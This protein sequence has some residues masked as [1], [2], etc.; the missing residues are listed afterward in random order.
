[1]EPAEGIDDGMLWEPCLIDGHKAVRINRGHPYYHK[2]Y[3]PNLSSGV[4][5]QGMDSLLWA[6]CAAELGTVNEATKRHFT[7]LRYEV[8]RLLRRL[9]DHL[10]EPDLES[11]DND[12]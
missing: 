10:P 1:M 4:T 12:T 7:E 11:N 3:V 2:V 5:V 8:S 6:L 9:V